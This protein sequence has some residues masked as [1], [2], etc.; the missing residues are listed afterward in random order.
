VSIVLPDEQVQ[1]LRKFI[2]DYVRALD[3]EDMLCTNP[4]CVQGALNP[5]GS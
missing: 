2:R 1:S 4:M 5:K 3:K